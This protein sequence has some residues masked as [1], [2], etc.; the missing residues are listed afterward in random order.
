VAHGFIENFILKKLENILQH[1]HHIDAKSRF[2]EIGQETNGV[3]PEYRFVKEEG[4]DHNKIFTMALYLGEKLVSEGNGSSK[5]KAEQEAAMQGLIA[6]KWED[7][8]LETEK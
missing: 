1:G 5:Q 6:M 8:K 7:F 4:P 2:Q 3:T